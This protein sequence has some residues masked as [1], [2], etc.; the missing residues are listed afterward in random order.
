MSKTKKLIPLLISINLLISACIYIVLPEGLD[1]SKSAESRS[2][3]AVIT[4]VS[5]TD[6]GD[7]HIDLT[8]RNDT[9]DWSMVKA[10]EGQPAI[11][12]IDGK[13]H[14]CATVFVGTGGHRLAPGFQM[15]GYISG[16]KLEPKVQL[17]YVEC[18]GVQAAPG[19]KL[20][21]NYLAYTGEMDY[22]HQDEGQSTGTLEVELDQV[23]TDLTY[24]IYKEVD[25]L[26]R[27]ANIEIT[28]LS[29]N[30]ISLVD[31]QR[32]T[33]GFEFKWRNY[34]P[35]E[36]ALKIHIGN[37]PVIGSDGIIYNRYEIMDLADTPLTPSGGDTEWT[38]KAAVP[39]D[40]SGCYILLSVESKNMRRYVNYAIDITDK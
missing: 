37:P 15:R 10:V 4:G 20:T 19:A 36:F 1:L 17:I 27:P 23:A 6:A 38:T 34:N 40:V 22:Y 5:Q 18:A 21:V 32:T 14:N 28:A 24:P 16:T 7:L 33:E 11:L 39:Q 31:V 12:T 26:V 8:I 25:G 35:T 3:S 13:K 9:G 30:I 2:W 29:D